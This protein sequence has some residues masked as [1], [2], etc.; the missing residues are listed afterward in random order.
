MA[1][2][3]IDKWTSWID[4]KI[5]NEVLAMHLHRF[6]WQESMNVAKDNTDLPHSYW[7]EYLYETY[8]V[9]QAAAIRRQVDKGRRVI[10]L[11]RLLEGVEKDARA[12]T[13]AYWIDT[14]WRADDQ[15]DRYQA[16]RQWDE[17]YGGDVGDHLDP[18][19]PKA[20]GA[21]L[22]AAGEDVKKYV[23]EN[24]AHTAAEPS[25]AEVTLSVEDVH[26]AMDAFADVFRR[27]YGLFTASTQATLT[28]ILPHDFF[29]VFRQPWMREGYKPPSG[30]FY[31]A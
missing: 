19:I 14:L 7:W 2:P 11:L 20:D 29:A 13:R 6:A 1:D 27:Y 30:P 5:K 26:R 17:H 25:V 21:A 18:A 10:S 3:R 24:I 8:A 28:P 4:G 23:D 12:I 31:D 16:G 9:T 15:L 22:R